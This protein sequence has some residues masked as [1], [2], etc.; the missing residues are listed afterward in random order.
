MVIKMSKHNKK[1]IRKILKII[2]IVLVSI[3]VLETGFLVYVKI[4]NEKNSVYIN[5]VSGGK[6]ITDGYVTVGKSDF[7]YS[8]QNKYEKTGVIKAVIT[9][10]D[11]KNKLIFESKLDSE[12]N[13]SFNDVIEI[14]DGFIAVGEIQMTKQQQEDN[15]SEAI[16]VKYDKQGELVWRKNFK[17]LDVNKF[18]KVIEDSDNNYVVVGQSIYQPNVIGNHATG[19]AIIVKYDSKGELL[20]KANYDGPKT[21]IYNDLI[22][23]KTGYIV[24]GKIKS[25]TGVVAKYDKNLKLVWRKLYGNTDSLGLR[26]IKA[27]DDKNYVVVGSKASSIKD[28]KNQTA[29]ILKY[30]DKGEKLKENEYQLNE[31]NRYENIFIKGNNLIINGV[32][33]KPE[34]LDKITTIVNVYNAE[35]ELIKENKIEE[36]KTVV[37]TNIDNNVLFGYTN[38]KISKVKSNGKDIYP[39]MLKIDDKYNLTYINLK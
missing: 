5:S 1:D 11:S 7:K 31:I 13:S 25:T 19:G 21:G 33:S 2:M 34:Q 24:V 4:R 39:V 30:N 6:T 18:V 15:T 16:I 32:S 10:Y 36:D 26:A 38:S 29:V 12:F 35:L 27:I 22:F 8:R 3:L 37:I 17:V 20:T 14:N 23:T 28:S 9:K